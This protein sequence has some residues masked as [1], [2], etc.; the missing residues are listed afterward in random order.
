MSV[1]TAFLWIISFRKEVVHSWLNSLS[2]VLYLHECSQKIFYF[3]FSFLP[4][5][6]VVASKKNAARRFDTSRQSFNTDRSTVKSHD[7]AVSTENR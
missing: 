2:T 3:R 5:A 4:S 7:V 6:R 1:F